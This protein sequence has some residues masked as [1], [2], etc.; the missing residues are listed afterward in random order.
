MRETR[1]MYGRDIPLKYHSEVIR[2]ETTEV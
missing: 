2:E 1:S